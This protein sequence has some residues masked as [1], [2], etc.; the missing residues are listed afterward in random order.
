VSSCPSLVNSGG[1]VQTDP[2]IYLLFWGPQW[3]TTPY[4]GYLNKVVKFFQ[5]LPG[6]DWQQ[7]LHAYSG[8]NGQ[9]TG[10]RYGGAAL[11]SSDPPVLGSHPDAQIDPEILAAAASQK[12]TM[13]SQT[14]VIVFTEPGKSDVTYCGIHGAVNT[15]GGALFAW[16][17]YTTDA[18]HN[19]P[20]D[21]CTAVYPSGSTSKIPIEG[22]LTW[23]ASHELAENA[24]AAAWTINPSDGGSEIGD[25]CNGVVAPF[26]REPGAG[27]YVQYLLDR[28]SGECAD[29]QAIQPTPNPSGAAYSY[30][31]GGVSCAAAS[32]CMAVGRSIPTAAGAPYATLAEAWNG[33]TWSVTPTPNPAGSQGSY[34]DGVSCPAANACTAVGFYIDSTGTDVTLSEAW[35][36]TNWTIEPTP[37]PA[38]SRSTTLLSV[39]C[40]APNACTA[41]GY[42]LDSS[43]FDATLAEAWN[44]TNWTIQP[45]PNAT[46]PIRGSLLEGVSCTA[47]NAC[48]GV[49][50]ATTS[51]APQGTAL[52]EAWNGTKWS[53]R[54]MPTY[55]GGDLAAVSCASA[56]ACTGVGNYYN[57]TTGAQG[58]LV[59]SWNGKIWFFSPTVLTHA[60]LYG[61][62][63]TGRYTC[64]A[65]GQ[66]TDN[67]GNTVTLAEDPFNDGSIQPTPNPAGSTGSSLTGVS[68]MGAHTCTAVGS[69]DTSPGATLPLA[70]AE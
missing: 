21:H 4:S 57:Q 11:D 13:N 24:T 3:T 54:S 59:A 64:T 5:L 7:A 58:T 10:V 17:P 34:L 56:T 30:L 62:S 16:I 61:V 18:P 41:V 52:A 49:G 45:T 36:G 69:Y 70:E 55:T 63:C 22:D 29:Y 28:V 48:T 27:V 25:P 44:G 46:S 8:S 42:Y 38:G 51:T 39:S 65:V 40:T 43:G 60:D 1:A 67:S 53:I 19:T 6:S 47:A 26:D 20:S 33:T 9:I 31:D 35:N 23:A 15:G 66:Y 14:Q 2:R 37:D 12:W 50:R 68:C 32:T